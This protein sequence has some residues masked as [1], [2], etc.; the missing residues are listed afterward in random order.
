LTNSILPGGENNISKE[1]I[2]FIP[3]LIS[4]RL[5]HEYSIEVKQYSV[6]KKEF[7]FWNNLKKVNE[8][9][10]DIFDSQPYPVISNIQNVKDAGEM[11]LGY[12]EV[13][14]VEKKRIFITARELDP[15]L[16]PHYTYDC[17]EIARS[18]QDYVSNGTIA[19]PPT[20]NEIYQMFMGGGDFVFIEPRYTASGTLAQLVFA[21]KICSDCGL[22]GSVIKPDFWID[23]E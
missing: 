14:A 19:K 16:L 13:S 9:G 22:T 7:D 21:R 5:T 1:Q 4:D 11:V 15:L 20:F 6:S 10:G 12:F 8:S 3:P 17:A 23:L 2:Q 18:P